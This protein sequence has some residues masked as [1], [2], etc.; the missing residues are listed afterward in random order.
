MKRK[1]QVQ[2][3]F[4]ASV[5]QFLFNREKNKGLKII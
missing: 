5:R 2:R 3:L 4:Q 1:L